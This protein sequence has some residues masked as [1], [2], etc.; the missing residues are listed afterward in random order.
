MTDESVD[1]VHKLKLWEDQ[2]WLIT[3]INRDC[4][5]LAF[6]TDDLKNDLE[7]WTRLL[8]KSYWIEPQNREDILKSAIHMMAPRSVPQPI[9]E[10]S[11]EYPDS[12]H[13]A[14]F[15]FTT[16][17]QLLSMRSLGAID[18]SGSW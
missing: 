2:D 10:L 4:S 17:D 9:M 5:F 11:K 7:F 1:A 8:A 15:S 16:E 6:L 3:A 14:A 18:D 12:D 13:S